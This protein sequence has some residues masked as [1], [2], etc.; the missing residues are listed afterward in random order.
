MQELQEQKACQAKQLEFLRSQLNQ[1][2]NQRTADQGQLEQL[3]DQV[4]TYERQVE[5][6]EQQIEELSLSALRHTFSSLEAAW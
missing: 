3:E 4:K 6:M 5:E 1:K 2:D